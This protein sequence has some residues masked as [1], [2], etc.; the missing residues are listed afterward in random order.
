MDLSEQHF[1]TFSDHGGGHYHE[2]VT[3]TNIEHVGY[4]VPAEFIYAI[5]HPLRKDE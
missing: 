1:H 5:D 3:P 4:F 2:D